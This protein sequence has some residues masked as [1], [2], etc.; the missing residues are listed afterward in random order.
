VI[1]DVGLVNVVMDPVRGG[2]IS[3]AA[4]PTRLAK[5]EA[6]KKLLVQDASLLLVTTKC[7]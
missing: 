3:E 5:A 4:L 1:D 7:A 2:G 6:T